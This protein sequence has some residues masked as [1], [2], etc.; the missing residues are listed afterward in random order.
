MKRITIVLLVAL[1]LAASVSAQLRADGPRPSITVT[2]EA[3]VTATPDKILITLGIETWDADVVAAKDRNGAI[4]KKALA[5]MRALGVADKDDQTDHL[6]IEPRWKDDYRHDTFIGFFVRNGL[7]VTLTAVGTV[8][9][10]LT[11]VLKAGVNYV[12]DIDFQT[13]TVRSLRDRAREL[14]LR[15]ATEKATAMAAVLGQ[16]IGAP[17][18]ISESYAGTPWSFSSSWSGWRPGR[19]PG[20][21]Q[22]VTQAAGGEAGPPGETVALGKIGI[23][24]GVS[25]TFELKQ[26]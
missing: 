15:A 12:H 1:A 13:T 7:V 5:A 25:V 21:M 4:L 23:R 6:S 2:G 16:S 22:N 8:E 11:S 19:A 17:L 3:L 24:A 26:P 18:Q 10:L 9:P 14:A 20:M